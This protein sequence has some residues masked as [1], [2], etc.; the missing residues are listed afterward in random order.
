[1]SS[2][3]ITLLSACA[4]IVF[5]AILGLGYIITSATR[6]KSKCPQCGASTHA[7][8]AF[9]IEQSTGRKI[10]REKDVAYAMFSAVG[11]LL[12]GAGACLW[13]LYSLYTALQ[14]DSCSTED[15]FLKCYDYSGGLRVEWT[16]NLPV[17]FVATLGG[18]AAIG[19]SGRRLLRS[20]RSIGKPKVCE[21]ACPMCKH[22]W[23]E[24][25][26]A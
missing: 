3:V 19:A 15:L 13:V 16:V 9:I 7:G 17:A 21:F 10:E 26:A 2:D 1:M 14:S 12:L 4:G 5:V 23:T 20:I 6:K 22:T 11:G 18:L 24:E 25:T 8:K